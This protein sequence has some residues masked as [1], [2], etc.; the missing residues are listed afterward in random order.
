MQQPTEPAGIFIDS[1]E[2][3]EIKHLKKQIKTYKFI[4]QS[5]LFGGALIGAYLVTDAADTVNYYKHLTE[6]AAT[7]AE[8][9]YKIHLQY[10]EGIQSKIPEKMTY[11][12]Q[13]V[14]FHSCNCIDY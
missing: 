3:A 9:T 13:S 5:L 11:E 6:R 4:I 10:H 12:S 14:F 1:I 2:N 7:V 8:K